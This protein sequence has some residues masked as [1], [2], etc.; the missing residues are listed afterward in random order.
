M[1]LP[2]TLNRGRRTVAAST[3]ASASAPAS[4][5]SFDELLGMLGGEGW[6]SELTE[7]S[8]FEE[9]QQLQREYLDRATGEL[10]QLKKNPLYAALT[11]G[12]QQMMSPDSPLLMAQ[13]DRVRTGLRGQLRA[14][15]QNAAAAGIPRSQDAMTESMQEATD[16][17][18]SL[19]AT[20]LQAALGLAPAALS[21]IAQPST[22]LA[23]MLG[24]VQVQDLSSVLFP[25]LSAFGSALGAFYPDMYNLRQEFPSFG[26]GSAGGLV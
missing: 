16:R 3:P 12:I 15:R 22:A 6:L 7:A 18:A 17:L 10:E 25:A 9:A 26:A 11:G 19:P 2:W 24:N 14:L 13:S 4:I 23:S 21:A 5:P 1:A 8:G 20:N